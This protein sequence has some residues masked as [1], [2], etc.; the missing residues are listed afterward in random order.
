MVEED[1]LTKDE[2]VVVE[3]DKMSNDND[4]D[5]NGDVAEEIGSESGEV[6]GPGGLG[7]CFLLTVS[8]GSRKLSR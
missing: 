3:E 7:T 2:V 5:D 4:D 6:G 8:T 1:K